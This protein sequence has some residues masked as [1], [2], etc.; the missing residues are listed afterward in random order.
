MIERGPRRARW[1][2]GMLGDDPWLWVRAA[3]HEV[4]PTRGLHGMV[5]RVGRAWGLGVIVLM[6]AWADR[7][8]MSLGEAVARSLHDALLR[9]PA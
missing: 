6:S 9:S 4:H 5:T 2:G 1:R 3:L 7:G 8:D